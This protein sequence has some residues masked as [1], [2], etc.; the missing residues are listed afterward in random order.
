MRGA[1]TLL[2]GCMRLERID[3][4]ADGPPDT[5][6]V[7]AAR[8]SSARAAES[9][10]WLNA[11]FPLPPCLGHVKRIW[12]ASAD[13]GFELRL[14]LG[15]VSDGEAAVIAWLKREAD[16]DT[17]SRPCVWIAAA[18]LRV[19][20]DR[21]E[22]EAWRSDQGGARYWPTA[23][24]EQRTSLALRAEQ[25]TEALAVAEAAAAALKFGLGAGPL[26]VVVDPRLSNWRDPE[27][28][29]AM[30]Q[31]DM[32]LS[33]LAPL[34]VLNEPAMAA[35]D[36]VAR[37]QAA[38]SS[39]GHDAYLCTG[40]VVLC[41][42]EPSI[43]GAMALVHARARSVVFVRPDSLRGGVFSCMRLQGVSRLNHH[44]AVYRLLPE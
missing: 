2:P 11:A 5:A 1:N 32:A 20:R 4:A 13:V 10:A 14:L 9:L 15:P 41:L 30:H 43:M 39:S 22:Y 31:D 38:S 27:T 34:P 12:R 16:L 33:F 29:T 40:C 21:G 24:H 35:V 25:D 3:G 28:W 23:F 6:Q 44:Y 26:A 19:P 17:D 8:I 18:P 42:E 37:A 36:A 7:Y